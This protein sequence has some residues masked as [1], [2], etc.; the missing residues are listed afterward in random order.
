ML[1]KKKELWGIVSRTKIK[2]TMNFVD[3]KN[4]NSKVRTFII[5][6]LHDFLFQNV[7]RAKIVKKN[8]ELAPKS[9]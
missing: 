2:L 8:L 6:G 3:M 1:L 5:M 7:I 4:K 9:I